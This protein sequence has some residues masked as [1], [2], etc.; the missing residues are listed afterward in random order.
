MK[1]RMFITT[2]FT[3]PERFIDLLDTQKMKTG[4]SRSEIVRDLLLDFEQ[5][6]S[7]SEKEAA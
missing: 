4:K 7:Q 6:Q 2:A 5:K 1:E 3:I